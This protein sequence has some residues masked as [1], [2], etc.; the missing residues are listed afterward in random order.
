MFSV[1]RLSTRKVVLLCVVV[2][3]FPSCGARE[4]CHDSEIA[5]KKQNALHSIPS[6][7]RR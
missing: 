1:I 2:P 3:V 4:D 5:K 6:G 7:M